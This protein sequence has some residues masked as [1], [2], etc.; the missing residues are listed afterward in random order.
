MPRCSSAARP[1]ATDAGADALLHGPNLAKA[2][3]LIKEAGYNGEKIVLLSATDQ[4]I[5]HG[6]ALVTQR[7]ADARPGSMSSSTPMIGAR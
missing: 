4:P 5:V 1:L 6:Q 3:A 7:V 2:K